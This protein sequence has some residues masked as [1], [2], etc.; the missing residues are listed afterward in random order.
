MRINNP[1]YQRYCIYYFSLL[2]L[3]SCRAKFYE[4]FFNNFNWFLLK[5][6]HFE[7]LLS[8]EKKFEKKRDTNSIWKTWGMKNCQRERRKISRTKF[9]FFKLKIEN[10]ATR[11]GYLIIM[12]SKINLII[13]LD[14][15]NIID[16]TKLI[17]L[18]KINCP[19]IQ[20]S[21]ILR[22]HTIIRPKRQKAKH[23]RIEKGKEG[24]GGYGYSKI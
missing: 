4:I 6:R 15:I 19:T 14:I 10:L 12:E 22:L 16:M 7:H 8:A 21:C 20:E 9:K 24:G 23:E 1:T 2:N 3:S 13:W 11:L 5:K 18:L 17:Q